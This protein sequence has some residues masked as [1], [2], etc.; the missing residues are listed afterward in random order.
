MANNTVAHYANPTQDAFQRAVDPDAPKFDFDAWAELARRD[1]EAFER[2]REQAVE[3]VCAQLGGRG[4][5]NIAGVLWRMDVARRRAS[6]PLH[7]CI[8]LSSMM[9]ARYFDMAEFVGKTDQSMRRLRWENDRVNQL[10]G[11][12]SVQEVDA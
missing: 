10:L 9:W 7:L 3:Q 1:P 8:K 4:K 11:Q 6:N 2:Q 12:Q 5:P